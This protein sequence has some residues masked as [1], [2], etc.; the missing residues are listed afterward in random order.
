MIYFN[1]EVSKEQMQDVE[2]SSGAS[3]TFGKGEVVTQ[4]EE[5]EDIEIL[6]ISNSR[7]P[8]NEGPVDEPA[9]EIVSKI[10]PL[11]ISPPIKPDVAEPTT[12]GM[13]LVKSLEMKQPTLRLSLLHLNSS[14]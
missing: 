4:G 11:E 1:L 2:S 8:A 10:P 6:E 12:I 9:K 5:V 13:L 3:T 14:R 7:E